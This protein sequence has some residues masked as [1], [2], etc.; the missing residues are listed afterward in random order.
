MMD[1]QAGRASGSSVGGR[2]SRVGR[3]AMVGAVVFATVWVVSV[4]DASA[5]PTASASA[6]SY[7]VGVA[8]IPEFV[9]T[10]DVAVTA[11]PGEVIDYDVTVFLRQDPPG[12][13]NGVIVCPIFGGTLTIVLPDG[14]GP[15]TI[16][17]ISTC[18]LAARSV[19]RTCRPEIHHR[20]GS[21]RAG[22][23]LRTG[24]PVFRSGA[25][26]GARRGDGRGSRRRSGGQRAG[27][28]NSDRADL[29]SGTFHAADLDPEFAGDHRRGADPMDRDRDQ[30]HASA[31]LPNGAQRH[32][33]RPVD[34]WPDRLRPPRRHIGQ[35]LGGRQRERAAQCRRDLELDVRTPLANTTLTATGFGT[36]A[37]VA[38]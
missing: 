30:R 13:P 10:D 24:C 12:T 36:G 3:Y 29:P 17:T 7:G 28:S 22:T 25:G 38:S 4:S 33:R 11:Y 21:R 6:P 27:P 15:F 14:S 19:S 34:P 9:G 37:L 26:D 8:I 2:I 35:L 1:R 23:G 20:P 31:V 32:P 16:A 18:P 5:A